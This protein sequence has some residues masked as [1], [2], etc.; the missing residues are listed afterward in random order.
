MAVSEILV[1]DPNSPNYKKINI[2][3][4]PP[5]GPVGPELTQNLDANGFDIINGDLYQSDRVECTSFLSTNEIRALDNT[6]LIDYVPTTIRIKENVD[7]QGKNIDNVFLVQADTVGALHIEGVSDVT[8]SSLRTDDFKDQTGVNSILR[9]VGGNIPTLD[10]DLDANTHDIYNVRTLS[11]ENG[12]VIDPPVNDADIVNKLYVDT[13]VGGR[14]DSITAGSASIVLTG[15]TEDVII[16]TAQNIQ[17]TATPQFSQVSVS[18]LLPIA[19]SDLSRKDYVDN[20]ISNLTLKK[21]SNLSDVQ[22]ASISRTNLGLGNVP[23]LKQNL[24]ATTAPTNLNDSSQGYAVGSSWYDITNDKAYLCLDDTL[25]NA[26][27]IES[28]SQG[29]TSITQLSDVN[30]TGIQPTQIMVWNGTEFISGDST[31]QSNITNTLLLDCNFNALFSGNTEVQDDSANA[32]V[33]LLVNMDG[34]NLV[35]GKISNCLNFNGTNEYINFGVLSY[36]NFNINDTFSANFWMRSTQTGTTT[37]EILSVG[38][39]TNG[40]GWF[41]KTQPSTGSIEI[42]FSDNSS[43]RSLNIVYAF[44]SAVL[45]D[46]NWHMITI[47]KTP[48]PYG[49]NVEVYLDGMISPLKNVVTST[50][51]P[52]DNITTSGIPFN[53]GARNGAGNNYSGDLDQVSIFNFP[54]VPAQVQSLYNNDV[55]TEIYTDITTVVQH[56]HPISQIEGL[57]NQLNSMTTD[58]NNKVSSVT[59]GSASIVIGGTATAPTVNTVQNIQ[60]SASPT[61]TGITLTNGTK[62]AA[63]STGNDIVNKTYAD[64]KVASVTAGS[65]SIVIG[66]TATA[67]TVDTVQNIQTTASPTFSAVNTTNVNTTN[68][69]TDVWKDATGVN[70]LISVATSNTPTLQQ[71]INANTR[72]ITGAGI[73][74]S[75]TVNTTNGN[76]TYL[77]SDEWRNSTNTN[78]IM[79]VVG[80]NTPTLQQ[81]MNANT[82]NIT[83]AGILGSTTVNTTNGNLTYLFSNEWRD[84][85][86][87]NVIMTVVGTNTPTLQQHMDFNNKDIYKCQNF[88][89]DSVYNVSGATRSF[90]ID[91]GTGYFTPTTSMHLNGQT[92]YN[93]NVLSTNS[94]SNQPNT[95]TM[96]NFGSDRVNVSVPLVLPTYTTAGRPTGVVGLN[97]FDTTLGLPI[98]HN[99]TN[100]IDAAGNIV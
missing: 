99:G 53:I 9:I 44:T 55:G 34:T 97:I 33:G 76:L 30:I 86:N 91:A 46:N 83:G 37:R 79:T 47:T 6:S 8:T 85:T 28:T 58:I 61:F 60:T 65:A 94:I 74:G 41:I 32:A 88:D 4:L 96:L 92:L 80:T 72:N 27:W 43:T 93:A 64:L 26:V 38:E 45:Y 48:G 57:Q 63:P 67:P 87:T 19:N 10:Q 68:L 82:K 1:N 18:S 77:F 24:S 13:L 21:L 98:W 5:N 17:T 15:T 11:I 100:Y 54:L 81:N 71:N 2:D 22:D 78:V 50:L 56:T 31:S 66:G 59:A 16:D 23:N 14:V 29:V 69:N 84:S 75:T 42:L 62:S 40:S 52:N 89:V 73:L 20:Q 25:N 70:T 36:L 90:Y 49:E 35:P 39:G 3:F 51:L 7:M 12:T 95:V